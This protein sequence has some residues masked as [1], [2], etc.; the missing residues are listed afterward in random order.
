MSDPFID[1]IRAD[2]GLGEKDVWELPQKR[3]TY[4]IKHRA[5][6]TI[7]AQAGVVF[8]MP[9][10]LEVDSPNGIAS[11]IVRG[12][13][14]ERSE[15]SI[16]ECSPKNNRNAYPLAM[17]EKRAKDRVILKLVG[18]H[19]LVYSEDELDDNEGIQMA[20]S[21]EPERRPSGKPVT[22]RREDGM[23]TANSLN[24]SG[25]WNAEF[26]R[27]LNEVET[28]PMLTKFT[29]EW[30]AKINTD[31]WPED[32]RELA[33]EEIRKHKQMLINRPAQDEGAF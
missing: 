6:E 4:L 17:S 23:R 30:S 1:K 28:V 19:G 3:G 9:V 26:M 11:L 5:C 27:E 31:D 13:M 2:Y 25:V 10:M 32:H 29:L 18:I 12:V 7:A 15:W 21:R 22:G 24:K 8:D 33:R 16:G 20:V 14:G